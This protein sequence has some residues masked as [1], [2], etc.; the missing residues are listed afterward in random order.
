MS[1]RYGFFAAGLFGI[2]LAALVMAL[3]GWLAALPIPSAVV[4]GFNH[5][6]TLMLVFT[7]LVFIDVPVMVFSFLAGL[8]LF[9]V[10]RRA[11]PALALVCAAPWVLYCSYDMLRAFGDM[12]NSTRLGLLFS[13]LIWSSIFT[14]PAGLLLATLFRGGWPSNNRFGQLPAVSS[15]SQRDGG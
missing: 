3:T 12:P 2:A 8:I 14:V 11:T 7:S 4:R 13:L 10:V 6:L 15:A 1:R 9:R 5:Q